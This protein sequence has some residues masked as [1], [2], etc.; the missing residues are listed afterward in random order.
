MEVDRGLLRDAT[1]RGLL[2]EETD[3]DGWALGGHG[4]RGDG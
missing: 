1:A 3:A 4:P 2:S